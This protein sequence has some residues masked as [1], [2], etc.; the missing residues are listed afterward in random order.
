MAKRKTLG[1]FLNGVVRD[2]HGQFDAMYRKA[3][4]RNDSIVRTDEGMQYMLDEQ[5]GSEDEYK[6]LQR[7]TDEKITL[8]INT[9]DLLNHYHFDTREEFNKFFFTDYA[10]EIFARAMDFPKATSTLGRIQGLAD[11]STLF[12]VVLIST[13]KDQAVSATYTFLAKHACR[14]RQLRFVDEPSQAWE[15]CDA[16]ISDAPEVFESKPQNKSSIKIQREYNTFSDATY[17]FTDL[18]TVFDR[19]VLGEIFKQD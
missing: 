10:F 6:E 16:I 3:Y 11:S 17:T 7:L 9:Y 1:I 15:F 12:D 19:G 14:I 4:I 13:E 8:P 5:E 18:Y 2:V